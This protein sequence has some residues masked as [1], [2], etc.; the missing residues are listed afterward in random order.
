MT[1]YETEQEAFWAGEFGDGYIERNQGKG[2]I[3]SNTALFARILSAADRLDSVLELGCNVGLNLAALRH[4][5]PEAELTGVEINAK[6]AALAAAHSGADAVANA[7]I[8]AF[9]AD[10]AWDLVFTKGVLIHIAPEKLGDVYAAL[11]RLSS[12]YLM[13]CEYY[14]PTPIEIE[15]RGHAGRLFKRDFAGELL[16]AFPDLR[17]VDYGFCWRRDRQFA[18]DDATWFLLEKR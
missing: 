12:R 7:S 4:L 1:G 17:L 5:L 11:Y 8:F 2:W 3:A 16:D 6:A 10:R 18:Q 15:Y 14:N 9:E 13:V